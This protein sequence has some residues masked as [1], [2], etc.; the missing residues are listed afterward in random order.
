MVLAVGVP[1]RLDVALSYV[2]TN[3]SIPPVAPLLWLAS[4]QIGERILA[5]RFAPLTLGSA[6]A[7]VR[8]PGPLLGALLLGSVVLGAVL[9]AAGGSVAYV[10][11]RRRSCG[12]PAGPRRPR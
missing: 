5:G 1:L 3:V 6:R 12:T 2:A 9:G 10:M 4:I 11:A 7:L 8:A